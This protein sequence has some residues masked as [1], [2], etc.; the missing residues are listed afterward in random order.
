[1]K[2]LK[3]KVTES[4][5][6]WWDVDNRLDFPCSSFVMNREKNKLR[7]VILIGDGIAIQLNEK[8]LGELKRWLNRGTGKTETINE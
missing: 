1:M 8:Q 2:P 7:V 3:G 4:G 5:V 6:T